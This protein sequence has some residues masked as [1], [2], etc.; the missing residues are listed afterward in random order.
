MK[1]CSFLKDGKASLG[2]VCGKQV[3]N[4]TAAARHP[5]SSLGKLAHANDATPLWRPATRKVLESACRSFSAH[6][7]PPEWEAFCEDPGS[8]SWLPPVHVPE[9][10]ICIG[11]NYRDHA[12]ESGMELPKEP[13]FFNKFNNALTGASGPILLP[14]N[15]IQV[16]YEA[17]LAVIV[18]LTAKRVSPEDAAGCV[19][20]YTILNDISARDWQ[21]RTGQWVSGKTFDTFAPCGPYLVT[22]DE[23]PDPQGLDIRLSLNGTVMQNS[24]TRNL[25]FGIPFLIS[26]LSHIFTLRPSDIIST[27]TPPG[28]GF[29]RRPQVFLRDGDLVEISVQNIGTMSHRCVA[30]KPGGAD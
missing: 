25:I 19:G 11:L 15:S 8:C 5:G 1:L 24:N 26:Y 30:E 6:G 21:F 13:V 29:A 22:P 20:G 3:V 2:M 4:L 14:S 17:E 12:A 28:V 7:V 23:I 18:G 16:D 9:K 27:G 10:I